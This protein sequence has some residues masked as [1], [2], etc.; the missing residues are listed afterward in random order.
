MWNKTRARREATTLLPSDTNLSKQRRKTSLSRYPLLKPPTHNYMK[1][2]C[3]A[4]QKMRDLALHVKP[5]LAGSSV[6]LRGP[7]E[8]VNPEEQ[9]VTRSR[10]FSFFTRDPHPEISHACA[11]MCKLSPRSLLSLSYQFICLPRTLSSSLSAL[12]ACAASIC[13]SSTVAV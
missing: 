8:D 2:H 10:S 1:R 11:V 3:C 9:R 12:H 4:E 5:S 6:I 7:T 13:C